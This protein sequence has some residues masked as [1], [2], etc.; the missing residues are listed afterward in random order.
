M[1]YIPPFGVSDPDAGWVNGDPTVGRQGSIPPAAVFE[2]P[3]REIIA[4]ISKSGFTPTDTDLQQ[5]AKS[6]RSQRM[7][8]VEDTGSDSNMSLAF[9]PPLSSYTRGLTIRVRVRYTNSSAAVRINA[10]SGNVFV[11]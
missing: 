4:V 10:G 5:L 11:R 1:K 6:V 2:N 3:Q 7:N 8:Y 9:D